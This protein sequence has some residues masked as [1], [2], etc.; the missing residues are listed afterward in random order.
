MTALAKIH[1]DVIRFRCDRS[2]ARAA[3]TVTQLNIL[4]ARCWA[5]A[6]LVAAGVFDLH[7]AVDELQLDAERDGLIDQFGQDL[8]QETL[9]EPFMGSMT[10]NWTQKA[11]GMRKAGTKPRKNIGISFRQ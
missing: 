4:R 8:I 1:Q 5:R 9:A 7:D 6:L 11:I 3:V 2:N 10:G